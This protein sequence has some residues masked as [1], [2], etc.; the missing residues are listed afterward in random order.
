MNIDKT[1]GQTR[2]YKGECVTGDKVP[3]FDAKTLY[4]AFSEHCRLTYKTHGL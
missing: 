3:V 1:T 4:G 2:A